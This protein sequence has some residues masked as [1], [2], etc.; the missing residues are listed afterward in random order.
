MR[1]KQLVKVCI[2][3]TLAVSMLLP[4][5]QTALAQDSNDLIARLKN[6]QKLQAEAR[7]FDAAIS[8][9]KPL[10]SKSK[11]DQTDLQTID[12]FINETEGGEPIAVKARSKAFAAAQSVRQFEDGVKAA[13]AG[14]D[15][16]AFV[17]SLQKDTRQVFDIPGARIAGEAFTNS[18][19]ADAEILRTVG[20]RLKAQGK[21]PNARNATVGEDTFVTAS[22]GTRPYAF[23]PPFDGGSNRGEAEAVVEASALVAAA[24]IALAC[25]YLGVIAARLQTGA[26]KVCVDAAIGRYKSCISRRTSGGLSILEELF[27]RGV[28]LQDVSLCVLLPI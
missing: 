9:L 28:Y 1:I 6:R 13:A 2:S 10:K 26:I 4:L 25:A 7:K 5:C 22:F 23:E 16:T 18:I 12:T 17:E 15:P 21:D 3:K 20:E 27:C 19:K 11:F 14:K 8:R 24:L